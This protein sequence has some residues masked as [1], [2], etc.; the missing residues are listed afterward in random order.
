MKKIWIAIASLALIGAVTGIYLWN[1]PHKNM[2]RAAADFKM[3]SAALFSDF[4]TDEAGANTK[5]LDKV[6]E[7][8]GVVRSVSKEDDGIISVTLATDDEL[9]G[10]ICQLDELTTHKRTEFQA[11]EKVTFKGICTGMLMDVVLV[12]C[13]EV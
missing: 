5:Y 2:N 6:I 11:G 9:A 13:V 3:E 12:R 7:V 4:E 1:K 10:V 8:T